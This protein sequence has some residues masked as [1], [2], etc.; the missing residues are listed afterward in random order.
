MYEYYSYIA[1]GVAIAEV[2]YLISAIW[3][4]ELNAFFITL[5]SMIIFVLDFL[6]FQF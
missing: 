2:L 6:Y 5:L 4:R 1:L 3:R